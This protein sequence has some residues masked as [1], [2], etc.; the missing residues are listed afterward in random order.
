MRPK[1]L[2]ALPVL[3]GLMLASPVFLG[4]AGQAPDPLEAKVRHELNMLPFFSVF[5][6]VTLEMNG[7][8][9]VLNGQV[10]RPS[11]KLDAE[12]AAKAV[13][14][15]SAVD[16]QLQVLPTSFFDD[17]IRRG[18]LRAIYGHSVLSRYGMGLYGPIRIIVRNGNVTLEGFVSSEMDRNIAG[19]QAGT[20]PGVFSVTNNLQISKS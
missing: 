11:L 2:I 18:E 6:Y 13:E 7:N 3:A 4:A 16:N 5:D 20:V 12:R 9:V 8:T 19:I 1:L 14:G 17:Q 10:S 15:V